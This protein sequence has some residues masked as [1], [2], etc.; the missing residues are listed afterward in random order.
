MVSNYDYYSI[1]FDSEHNRY[2]INKFPI[3]FWDLTTGMFLFKINEFNG[4]IH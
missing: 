3:Y 1:D 4:T 2:I